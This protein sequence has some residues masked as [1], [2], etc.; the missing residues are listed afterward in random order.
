M[1][2]TGVDGGTRMSKPACTRIGYAFQPGHHPSPIDPFATVR[3][4]A[5]RGE[6]VRTPTALERAPAQH[7]SPPHPL[8]PHNE[9]TSAVAGMTLRENDLPPSAVTPARSMVMLSVHTCRATSGDETDRRHAAG[10]AAQ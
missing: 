6:V 9:R 1:R 3:T 5:W 4:W 7:T 10:D 8:Q 2:C